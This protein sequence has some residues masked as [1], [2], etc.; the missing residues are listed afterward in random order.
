M[1]VKSLII[2]TYIL[3]LGVGG[4]TWAHGSNNN[5][6]TASSNIY[7]T[8]GT[9]K[10]TYSVNTN[11][12]NVVRIALNLF[13]NDM[14][15]VTGF[16]AKEKSNANIQ[17]FQ[18]DQLTN[19]EFAILSKLGTPLHRFITQKEAF[20]IGTRSG[21]LIV[22]GSD[23]RGTA[24][25]VMELSR[26]A[27][28]SPWIDW[29][30]VRPRQSK[31]LYVKTGFESL[32]IP[33]VEYRGLALN[34]STW[35]K[36]QNYSNLC[37]LMLRLRANTLWQQDAK[38]ETVHN[39][40]VV[41]SFDINIGENGKVLELLGKKHK[42]HHKK[43]IDNVKMLWNDNQL[44]FGNTSPGI[45]LKELTNNNPTEGKVSHKGHH[46]NQQE[47]AW[48]ANV[49]NPK[50]VAYQLSLFMDMAWNK[51]SV[52]PSNLENHLLSWLTNQFGSNTG[53]TLFPIMKEYYRLTNIRQP[54]YMTRP[55]GDNEFHSGE[56]G[57]ELERYLYSYDILKEQVDE[58][59]RTIPSY[60][61]DGFF[62]TIKFPI[63][64]A[65]LT[66]EKELE[67][68]EARHIARPGLFQNDDEAKAAAAL[69]LTAYQELQQLLS[70]YSN[71]GKG[72]W[73]NLINAKELTMLPPSLPGTLS[74]SDINRYLY[75]A[76]DR[77]E[78]LKPL[79]TQTQD[80][81]A[82]NAY[83]WTKT[84]GTNIELIPLLGH[85][86]KAV[87][88]PRGASLKYTFYSDKEGDARFTIAGIP[89]YTDTKGEMRVS[90]SID[91]EEPVICSLKE[92]YN[93]KDWKLNIWRGQAQKSFYTTLYYGNHDIEIKAL[94]DNVIIDQWIL[95]FDVDREYYMIPTE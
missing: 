59:E 83:E 34:N 20:Y 84:S 1:N 5:N 45:I 48:I 72:K 78:D 39:K 79:S 2:S 28:V 17:I 6:S 31:S 40:A 66:A 47:E 51:Q 7:W 24:Y 32:Q 11:A 14:K 56:F 52:R 93:S 9:G 75:D 90:I 60:Q 12:S 68:Q 30:D 8:D 3:F 23:A 70:H 62:E 29:N 81:I 55:F 26:L 91:D 95:D 38:H 54:E 86:N 69:S 85:S 44:W 76:F 46:D 13:S 43:S 22:V 41:D 4:T 87:E 21:K 71:I 15:A 92:L 73:K 27:G 36:S 53:R 89:N 61:K 33:S 88:L 64:A 16:A 82:K 67:A 57:N 50:M 94:D 80:V 49:K 10:V 35:M 65:A 77:T 25:G 18:L 58:T 37:R 63:Y 42:K 74:T 19:K